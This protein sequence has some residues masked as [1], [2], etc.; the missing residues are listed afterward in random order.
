MVGPPQ[1]LLVWKVLRL[2]QKQPSNMPMPFLNLDEA[3]CLIAQ[4][5]NLRKKNA[6]RKRKE[7]S[8]IL[9]FWWYVK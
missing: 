7:S 9:N 3:Q 1:I 2:I 8:I 4:K 6:F 5:K